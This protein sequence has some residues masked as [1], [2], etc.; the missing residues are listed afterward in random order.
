MDVAEELGMWWRD[1]EA[2]IHS[3][4]DLLLFLAHRRFRHPPAELELEEVDTI[5]AQQAEAQTLLRQ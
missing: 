5:R 1:L 2:R 4:W 3:R